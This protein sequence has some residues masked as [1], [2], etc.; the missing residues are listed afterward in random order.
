MSKGSG[1]AG[2]KGEHSKS[3]KTTEAAGSESGGQVFIPKKTFTAEFFVGLF[4]IIGLACLSYLAVD[5]AN[6]AV[7]GRNN[8]SI[9]A[10]F[11]NISGVKVGA[12]VE[13]AG[14]QVG[15][16]AGITLDGTSAKVE[17]SIDNSVSIRDDDIVAVR[18]KGIIGDRYL[19][20]IP[21]SSNIK[22]QQGDSLMDTESTVELEELLGKFM[23]KVE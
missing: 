6:M 2:S 11:D 3:S 9:T 13:I 12:P 1:G 10:I 4:F 15:E 20:I 5:L 16:I 8:Y 14:V 7:F 17:M 19:K 21:G 22:L 18:T 23:H